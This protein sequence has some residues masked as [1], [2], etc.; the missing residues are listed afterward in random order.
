M[1]KNEARE[2]LIRHWRQMTDDALASATLELDAGH[3]HFTVN[4]LYYAC[5]YAVTGLM[6]SDDR[7]FSRHSAVRSELHR[8]YIKS[9]IIS[10]QWGKFYDSLFDDR[11]EGDYGV[12][13]V[14]DPEDI[15]ARLSAAQ[16]FAQLIRNLIGGKQA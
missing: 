16:E 13:A 11:M 15:A 4:R 5:F 6:Q 1:T 14:F 8:L 12:S 2:I 7:Q 10:S 3:L 9:G